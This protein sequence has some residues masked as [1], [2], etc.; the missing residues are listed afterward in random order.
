MFKEDKVHLLEGTHIPTWIVAIVMVLWQ[1]AAAHAGPLEDCIQ[2]QEM[3]RRIQGCT[4]RIRQFPKDAAAFFNRGSAFMRRG[5]VDLAIADMTA[6]IKI[7]P[8]YAA[9]Y[10]HRGIA[11]EVR[12]RYEQAIA[13]FSKAVELNPRHGEAF[14][15]RAR[16]YLKTNQKTLALRD[17]VRAV[18]LEPLNTTFLS[19]RASI[20]E[21]LGRAKD[22]TADYQQVLS[23]SPSTKSAIDGLKRLGVSSS[24]L[25]ASADAVSKD[26]SGLKVHQ[27]APS[28]GYSREE[29]ECERAQH[30]DP[31][32]QF[33]SYPCWARSAFTSRRR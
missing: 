18:S 32:G 13:D 7:D 9:A 11:Y 28:S 30:S 3:D 20:Y 33:D 23:K 4:D 17:A 22:A 27:F 10:Y 14:E 15:A 16:I 8:A 6:V 5:D 21:V 31:A 12:E 26:K 24:A 19:T 2:V 1:A 29:V 25:E